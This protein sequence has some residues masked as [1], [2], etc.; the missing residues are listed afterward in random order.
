MEQR[1]TLLARTR[2]NVQ[3]YFY[4]TQ[5]AEIRRMLP[6]ANNT[7]EEALAAYERASLPGADSFGRCI[8]AEGHY[9]GDIWCYGIDRGGTLNAMLSYCI[10]EKEYWK[11]GVATAAVT[12]FLE[13]IKKR[14]GLRSV[15]AFTYADNE[16]SVR[17]LEK[18]DFVCKERFEED[19]RDSVYYEKEL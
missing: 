13:Q 18:N 14:F 1:I 11:R 8:Y 12:L 5:D 3:V 4:R 2:E 17:V 19:G 15:G 16:G 6:S 9:I 7:V 10:F